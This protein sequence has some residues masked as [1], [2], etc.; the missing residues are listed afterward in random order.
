MRLLLA[1]V[2]SV[3]IGYAMGDE[4]HPRSDY[5]N[6]LWKSGQKA[7]VLEIADERLSSDSSDILG[8]ILKLEYKIEYLDLSDIDII[9]DNFLSA[10]Y[11]ISSEHFS[12][13]LP[14]IELTVSRVRLAIDNYPQEYIEEDRLKSNISNKSL[15]FLSFIMALEDDGLI[16]DLYIQ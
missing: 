11:Q 1:V 14:R 10:T 2:L 13:L 8:L 12:A 6:E 7:R 9:L 16:S 3:I 15:S 5:L 4:Q